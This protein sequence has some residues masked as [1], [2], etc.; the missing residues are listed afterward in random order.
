MGFVYK[1]IEK[2]EDD[3]GSQ[4]EKYLLDNKATSIEALPDP[5]RRIEWKFVKEIID[6]AK[7]AEESTKYASNKSERLQAN[8][9]V[10]A[11]MLV[12]PSIMS[13]SRR[14]VTLT[15]FKTTVGIGKDNEPD[16][17]EKFALL[18]LLCKFR[19]SE[20]YNRVEQD[21][22]DNHL[23]KNVD[24]EFLSKFCQQITQELAAADIEGIQHAFSKKAASGPSKG[25]G[26]GLFGGVTSAPVNDSVA[27]TEP[28]IAHEEADKAHEV[29]KSSV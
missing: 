10:T 6:A 26:F 22:R 29:R 24:V 5:Y 9:I 15:A 1:T 8:K 11:V 27:S 2:I 16:A 28:E 14:E 18:N 21:F 3:F 19:N 25:W 20:L 4:L 13:P 23:V 7:S 17:K 12:L